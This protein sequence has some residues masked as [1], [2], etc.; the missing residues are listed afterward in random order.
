[1]G[2]K[3]RTIR[4]MV[5]WRLRFEIPENS[6]LYD[7]LAIVTTKIDDV[8][9]LRKDADKAYYKAREALIDAVTLSGDNDPSQISD[10][11]DLNARLCETETKAIE[12]RQRVCDLWAKAE[13]LAQQIED[14][15][16]RVYEE[17]DHARKRM[18]RAT[19]GG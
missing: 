5:R 11:D 7:Q 10:Y 14:T 6:G 17:R 9:K 16:A 4:A 1:M 3:K 13:V 12:L 8:G 15:D 2:V 19:T 18:Q